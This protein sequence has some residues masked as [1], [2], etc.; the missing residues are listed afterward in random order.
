MKIT[1]EMIEEILE[2]YDL[3]DLTYNQVCRY[4]KK[5]HGIEVTPQ[6]VCY[7]LKRV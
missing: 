5:K 3:F 1:A 6:A 2:P 4:L 7:R